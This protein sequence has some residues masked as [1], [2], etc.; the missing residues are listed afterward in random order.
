MIQGH[1]GTATH[2][3]QNCLAGLATSNPE[4]QQLTSITDGKMAVTPCCLFQFPW[5]T[6]Y[7]ITQCP[8]HLNSVFIKSETGQRAQ[9]IVAQFIFCFIYY[10]AWTVTFTLVQCFTP[11]LNIRCAVHSSH[12]FFGVVTNEITNFS[13]SSHQN[14]V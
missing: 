8:K 1:T 5:L 9:Q 4:V 10:D 2:T 14:A 12:Q 3:Q 7:D 13:V 11:R 6:Q